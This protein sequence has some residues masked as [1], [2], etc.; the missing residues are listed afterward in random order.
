MPKAKSPVRYH[1]SKSNGRFYYKITSGN[2]K[3]TGVGAGGDDLGYENT[4]NMLKGLNA[5]SKSL[6]SE[7]VWTLNDLIYDGEIATSKKK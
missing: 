4:R 7:K 5:V 3:V 2:H 6:G 1:K